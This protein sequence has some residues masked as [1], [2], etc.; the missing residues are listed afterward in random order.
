MSPLRGGA[1]SGDLTS[2]RSGT[3]TSCVGFA[4]VHVLSNVPYTGSNA[5]S[6][7]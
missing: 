2:F 7:A 4:Y 3:A 5:R 1:P 6:L